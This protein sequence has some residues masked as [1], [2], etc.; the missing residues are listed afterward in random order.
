V[1]PCFQPPAVEDFL[2]NF[3]FFFFGSGFFSL[4]S[5]C[6]DVFTRSTPVC[7]SR[8]KWAPSLSPYEVHSPCLDTTVPVLFGLNLFDF[9]PPGTRLNLF[10]FFGGLQANFFSR[11][12]PFPAPPRCPT[13]GVPPQPP[14]PPPPRTGRDSGL[15]F[16]LRFPFF[17]RS[18]TR[19]L[20]FPPP[21][22][23]AGA[24]TRVS[25][26]FHVSTFDVFSEC[27]VPVRPPFS[28]P[29]PLL[30]PLFLLPF[31]F[32]FS[33]HSDRAPEMNGFSTLV[34]SPSGKNFPRFR[35]Q[36]P[37]SSPA[38]DPPLEWKPGHVAVSFET[39]WSNTLS[40]VSPRLIVTLSPPLFQPT[41]CFRL[42]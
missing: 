30:L 1:S 22:F 23:I 11:F 25:F 10:F 6:R 39:R 33:R 35:I 20:P 21:F 19:L 12:F 36:L 41:L 32:F 28:G 27:E 42:R 7:P 5:L 8:Y 38:P 18:P 14:P 13:S 15:V 37:L 34:A 31:F 16:S 9:G 3:F 26:S 24:C 17:L 4:F 2:G 40:Q 29:S